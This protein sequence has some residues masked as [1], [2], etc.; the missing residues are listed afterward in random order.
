MNSRHIICGVEYSLELCSLGAGG[1]TNIFKMGFTG[2]S[3]ASSNQMA[4]EFVNEK[5]RKALEA[6]HVATQVMGA[7]QVYTV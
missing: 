1:L 4:A 7:L 2:V 5:I 3:K 6:A